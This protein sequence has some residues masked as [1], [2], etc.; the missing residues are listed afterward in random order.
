MKRVYDYLTGRNGVHVSSGFIADVDSSKNKKLTSNLLIVSEHLSDLTIAELLA[1]VFP[2]AV[3][4]SPQVVVM[5]MQTS[6]KT[7]EILRLVFHYLIDNEH[8]TDDM[9]EALLKIFN[10]GEHMVTRRPTTVTFR[11]TPVGEIK[12]FL[13]LDDKKAVFPGQPFDDIVNFVSTQSTQKEQ[14]VFN[15]ELKLMITGPNLPNC[16]FTDLPGMVTENM[17][18]SKM[19]DKYMRLPNVILVIVEPST[20]ED[21]D[22]SLVAPKLRSVIS[23]FFVVSLLKTFF[24]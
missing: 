8:F 14:V 2:D 5:G 17:Q 9:G 19:V 1:K 21:F 18:I 13:E 20:L 16:S 12:I 7:S 24:D 4:V 23:I 3:I 22:T 6:G 10:T 15:E 11:K